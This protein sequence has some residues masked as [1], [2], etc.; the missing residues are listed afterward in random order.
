LAS[1]NNEYY[2]HF[3]TVDKN[4]LS[5]SLCNG[6]ATRLLRDIKSH[7]ERYREKILES[8]N[9]PL[10]EAIIRYAK[11]LKGN[12][13]S[14]KKHFSMVDRMF[15]LCFFEADQHQAPN[16]RH[17]KQEKHIIR[18]GL[19]EEDGSIKVHYVMFNVNK[20]HKSYA[21]IMPIRLSKHSIARLLYRFKP[22]ELVS[23]LATFSLILSPV[24]DFVCA[25][26]TDWERN[27]EWWLYVPKVGGFLFGE[28]RGY[29]NLITFV[30]A[31]KL[32][33]EQLE[34]GEKTLKWIESVNKDFSKIILDVFDYQVARTKSEVCKITTII[35]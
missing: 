10:H 31:N 22:N 12:G 2:L 23:A 11:S 15:N 5:E 13:V 30:D 4:K 18:A 28:E 8:R 17:I 14:R 6:V 29:I 19:T 7:N 3:Y 35:Q 25:N 20:V 16:T 27:E 21:E 33:P 1:Q 32:K 26:M 34:E 24:N 9:I